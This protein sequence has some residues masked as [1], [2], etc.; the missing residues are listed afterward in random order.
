MGYCI[1][2][3][4]TNMDG[5][6]ITLIL[7]PTLSGPIN[8]MRRS[9]LRGISETLITGKLSSSSTPIGL[10]TKPAS[11]MTRIFIISTIVARGKVGIK[12]SV[13]FVL[14]EPPVPASILLERLRARAFVLPE[15]L[16]VRVSIPR[17]PPAPA[18]RPLGPLVL[19]FARLR[20][21]AL[22]LGLPEP[23]VPASVPRQQPAPAFRP[24]GPLVLA[25]RP[26]GLPAL[27]VVNL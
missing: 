2:F 24:L 7:L 26:L 22:A 5:P 3:S 20:P 18:F 13:A 17:R 9:G 4:A 1:I 12:D 10:D 23:L 8:G 27:P 6:R 15:R 14:L 16:R 25:F 19:A 21:P 11:V